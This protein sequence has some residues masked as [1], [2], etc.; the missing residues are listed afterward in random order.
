MTP[1]ARISAAIEL[2]DEISNA[3][4]Q[5]ERRALDA[6]IAYY[7]RQRRYIGSKDRAAIAEMVYYIV[8]NKEILSW[9]VDY[10]QAPFT[11][12]SFILCMLAKHQRLSLNDITHLFNGD[13]FAPSPL[14]KLE[15]LFVEEWC[16]TLLLNYQ[17][18]LSTRLNFPAWMESLLTARFGDRLQSEMQALNEEAPVDIRTNLLKT[19]REALQASLASEGFAMAATPLSPIGLRMTKR[20]AIFTSQAFKFGWFEMQD[21]A[22]QMVALMVDARPGQKVI[23][24][25]AGAGGKTLALAAQMQNKGQLLAWDTSKKR[26]EQMPDRIK[27][28]GVDN[29]RIHPIESENDAF[30]KR[31][32]ETADRVL[33]DAP[34]SG[35]GTWRRNPDLKWRFSEKDL[36]EIIAI[37]SSILDSASR[38]VK[39]GGRL[40]YAT[41]SLFESENERQIA[42]LLTKKANF[43][44]VEWSKIWDKDSPLG[45]SP[46]I[47]ND[48]DYLRV[49]P[50]KDGVDGFF[51]AVLER[52]A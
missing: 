6:I 48:G 10:L 2:M 41:C 14:D 34:C 29:V 35:S 31:H 11:P 19:T 39:V 8:R 30:I 9:W 7:F 12:R 5:P 45:D 33:V 23:D 20:S 25:C 38:L 13:R 16:K 46:N 22:S 32:K 43:R 4:E 51:A 18:P 21:A 27:R 36:A 50:H 42:D 44:V 49:S 24:F 28:A 26:L 37:Q 40:I 15:K 3:W 52:H 47:E 1:G 17:M